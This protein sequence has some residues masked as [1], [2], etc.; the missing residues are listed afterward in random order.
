MNQRVTMEVEMELCSDAIFGSGYSVP[1]GEDIGVCRDA[2]GYPYLRG[3]TLKGLLRQSLTDLLAWTGGTQDTL[4]GILGRE[5]WAG[6]QEDRQIQL[7]DLTM[8][9]SPRDPEDCFALR[10]FTAMENGVVKSR[11]LRTAACIRRGSK[12]R[13]W[14]ECDS[15]DESLIRQA[16]SGIKW[17]GTMRSRGF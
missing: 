15:G 1:A 2:G 9:D 3:S 14:L 7:T 17:A 10:T 8:K 4:D 5:G 11:S 13:G 6:G 12:F 16:L